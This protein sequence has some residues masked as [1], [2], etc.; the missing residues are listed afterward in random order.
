MRA[1]WL[2]WPEDAKATA[3][4][5]E[6][7]WG[8]HVLV[9]PVLEAGA[10]HRTNYLPAGAWWDFWTNTR[11]QGGAEVTREVDL[12]TIPVYVRAGAVIPR[13]PV[14]QY[15][16]EPSEEPVTLQIYPGADG[17]FS[18]YEDDGISFRYR[19]GEF[20]RIECTWEDTSR[21]L[22]LV[23]AEGSRK[24][25]GK[26][27]RVQAMDSGTVKMVAITDHSTVIEL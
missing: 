4:T 14:R 25:P 24:F 9:S 22:T 18:W 16:T 8:D 20:T 5:D 15:V 27:V 11:V 7:L 12:E 13:G 21:K 23:W 2:A 26:R 19:Q 1:L 6:Y 17:N 10:T 3:I